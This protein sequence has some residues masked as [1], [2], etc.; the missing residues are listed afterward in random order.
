ME[1]ASGL[2][3][4][5]T[6]INIGHFGEAEPLAVYG[7]FNF[8]LNI[9][10]FPIAVA[11]VE[12]SGVMCAV[13]FGEKNTTGLAIELYRTIVTLA[14]F[15]V[16][17]YIS[18]LFSKNI[19][20]AANVE[21]WLAERASHLLLWGAPLFI[22]IMTNRLAQAF[23]SAQN[24][25]GY[26][27]WPNIVSVFVAI[28][29]L[30]VF[31]VNWEMKE[32]GLIPARF[33]QESV[34]SA[35]SLWLLIKKVDR[36]SMAFP[37]W[38][39][40]FNGY[41][42]FIWKVFYSAL[43]T[44]AEWATYEVNTFLAV[45]MRDLDQLAI[46]LAWTGISPIFYFIGYGFSTTIRVMIG[47][48]IGE[49]HTL[50]ARHNLVTIT[51]YM[52]VFSAICT[53]V[54]LPNVR[55][56]AFIFINNP[57][58]AEPLTQTLIGLSFLLCGYIFFYPVFQ[59]FRLIEEELFFI[60]MLLTY[61]VLTNT[62]LAWLLAFVFGLKALGLTI[63]HGFAAITTQII[64]LY[65]IFWLHDWNTN[66]VTKEKLRSIDLEARTLYMSS[67]FSESMISRARSEI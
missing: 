10:L 43:G 31:V 5:I 14:V 39:A 38:N 37:G 13:R 67:R 19:F 21:S 35:T 62:V 1:V 28:V 46:F 8:F 33:L 41:S 65:K 29:G 54:F 57:V 42:I 4:L 25:V 49:G 11:V 15:F 18:V 45:Q 26:F 24:L 2:P 48:A 66:V 20:D 12:V 53:I 63:A 50:N 7:L 17:M 32:W 44:V 3:F 27:F 22:L 34:V 56:V 51:F 60:K 61:F 40:I 6:F 23:L 36:E 52:A 58:I 16:F 64:F 30:R 9:L 47:H 59:V 55:L